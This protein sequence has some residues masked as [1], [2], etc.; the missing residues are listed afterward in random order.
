ML[1]ISWFICG[2]MYFSSYIYVYCN[3]IIR[4][5]F[6]INI[7]IFLLVFISSL[8]YCISLLLETG[9]FRPF[10]INIILFLLIKII[11]KEKFVKI[12]LGNILM[13]IIVGILEL[14]FGIIMVAML[15]IDTAFF[16]EVAVGYIAVNLF[17]LIGFVYIT[18][19]SFIDKI[20]E[21]IVKWYDKNERKTTF[22]ISILIVS[23]ITFV[24]YNNFINILPTSIMWLANL[25]C[26][27]AFVFVIAFFKEK[28]NNS[29]IVY[30]YD[31]LMDYIKT[32]EVLLDE[33][34]K[35]QHEYKNQLILVKNMTN[36]AKAK[37]YIDTLLE[38]ESSEKSIETMNKLKYIPKGGLKGLIYYKIET[39]KQKKISV[40]IDV[41]MELENHKLW[42]KCEDN[43]DNI[44]KILGV[45]L[46]NAIE[47]A[48][49]TKEKYIIFES[50]LED[51]NI[52]FK[53]SNT[54]KEKIDLSK[55]DKLGFST[56]GNGKG[57]GLALVKEIIL[58]NK[59]LEQN[60]ELSGIYYIQKLLIK[61]KV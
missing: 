46:D 19:L 52:V 37:K 57:Y 17:I 34:N 6:K 32:Y 61:N 30:E 7:K 50:Y 40:F 36:N 24:L 2:M 8:I 47:A 12:I 1:V 58:K 5:Q 49:E 21:H 53:I 31:L 9:P 33:K 14:I 56:K 20:I 26:I 29:K 13:L 23:M 59:Y 16:S 44:S 55:I 43:L 35:N 22:V 18:K 10:M 25:F 42:K 39:M 60:R 15:K 51:N 54:Y 48:E 38:I 3:S 41:S 28:T 45:Y 4:K 27:A 11:Y